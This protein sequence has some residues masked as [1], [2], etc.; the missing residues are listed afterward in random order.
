MRKPSPHIAEGQPRIG[1][2]Y[3]RRPRILTPQRL[4][5]TRRAIVFTS[6]LGGRR[7][8]KFINANIGDIRA[9]LQRTG[10]R[11]AHTFATELANANVSVYGLMKLL[12]HDRGD[13]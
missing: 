8:E 13:E 12:G 3:R 9:G 11:L 6:L 2:R 1:C 4:A 7:A 10:T 5:R